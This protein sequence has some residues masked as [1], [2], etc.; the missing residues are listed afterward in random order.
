[1]GS[2]SKGECAAVGAH[3]ILGSVV[4]LAVRFR[5]SGHRLETELMVLSVDLSRFQADMNQEC[6]R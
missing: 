4:T 2:L 6:R 1:M 5:V 3:P